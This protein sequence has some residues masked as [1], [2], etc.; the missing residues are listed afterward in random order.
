MDANL[1][2]PDLHKLFN[3]PL[4]PGLYSFISGDGA[5]AGRSLLDS[6]DAI[7][8]SPVPRLSV[9]TAGTKMSD[10]SELL[11]S[12]EMRQCLDYLETQWDVIVIDGPSMS[13]SAGSG[14]I[15]PLVDGVVLVAAE[16]QASSKSVEE[17]V[18]ELNALGAHAIGLVYCK[19]TE[20]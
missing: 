20:S 6:S 19:A 15:A 1:N 18:T 5:R 11:A 10:P 2:R 13:T 3:I 8:A 17:S 4:S 9:L 16:G 12:A 14:V 7:Q